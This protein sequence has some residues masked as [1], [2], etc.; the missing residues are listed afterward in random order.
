MEIVDP[1][2]NSKVLHVGQEH[3]K[4]GDQL[5]APVKCLMGYHN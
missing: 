1:V 5:R 4:I 2:P 3:A